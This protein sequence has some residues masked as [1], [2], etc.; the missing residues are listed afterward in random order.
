[1]VSIADWSY[2]RNLRNLYK[3]LD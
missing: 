3:P 2:L 1:M